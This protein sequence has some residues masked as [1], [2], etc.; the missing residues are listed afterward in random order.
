MGVIFSIQNYLSSNWCKEFLF[1]EANS[2]ITFPS[3]DS[4]C[5]AVVQYLQG[6]QRNLAV[7]RGISD[8]WG[9]GELWNMVGVWEL[10]WLIQVW[11][12]YN[13]ALEHIA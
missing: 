3:S 13:K 9:N 6:R 12:K 4:S 7:V 5:S 11:L 2:K 8:F 1:Q 10:S